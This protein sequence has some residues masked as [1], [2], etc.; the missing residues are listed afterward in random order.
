MRLKFVLLQTHALRNAMQ[1]QLLKEQ[2]LQAVPPDNTALASRKRI[3]PK[4]LMVCS[5][6]DKHLDR[7]TSCLKNAAKG[8][9]QTVT[10]EHKHVIHT[11]DM[12]LRF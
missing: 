3:H 7:N 10:S 6:L 1:C 11:L 8:M 2:G 9:P 5:T 12:R 4:R